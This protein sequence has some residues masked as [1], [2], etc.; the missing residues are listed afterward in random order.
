MTGPDTKSDSET[1]PPHDW[2]RIDRGSR[3]RRCGLVMPEDY[4]EQ[5]YEVPETTPTE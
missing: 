3:C 4:S 1:C 5:D 2:A